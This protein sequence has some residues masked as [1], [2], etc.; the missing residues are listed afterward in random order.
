MV[1]VVGGPRLTATLA[2]SCG[3]QKI[4]ALP[5]ETSR[6]SD[7]YKEGF[8]VQA[9]SG[10]QEIAAQPF[11]Y[12]VDWQLP[13]GGERQSTAQDA[14]TNSIPASRREKR[15]AEPRVDSLAT[16]DGNSEHTWRR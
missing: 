3:G 9:I 5:G 16:A 14:S 13:R 15:A 11:G 6:G 10:V 1:T 8:I 4:G 7:T 2:Y 12:V